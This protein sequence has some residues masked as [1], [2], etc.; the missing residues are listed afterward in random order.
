M[1]IS[2]HSS[3]NYTDIQMAQT[4]KGTVTSK[5]L[6]PIGASTAKSG[7]DII[8]RLPAKLAS[9][10]VQWGA[11]TVLSFKATPTVALTCGR[12]GARGFISRVHIGTQS[13][14]LGVTDL[15]A[16]FV[17]MERDTKIDQVI[18]GS[19]SSVYEGVT[20]GNIG[21]GIATTGADFSFTLDENILAN[22]RQAIYLGSQDE[23]EITL[24]LQDAVNMG[25][26]NAGA[27][28]EVTISNIELH[29]DFIKLEPDTMDMVRENND[30]FFVI[31]TEGVRLASSS[32]I[33]G[34][35]NTRVLDSN[36]RHVSRFAVAYKPVGVLTTAGSY[37][38]ARCYP[39]LTTAS[40]S[41]NS[42]EYPSKPLKGSPNNTAEFLTSTLEANGAINSGRGNSLNA[43]NNT[44]SPHFAVTPALSPYNFD[45]VAGVAT[46]VNGANQ[47]SFCLG[48]KLNALDEDSN[49]VYNGLSTIGA[50]VTMN[51]T[52]S[53]L[54]QNVV[55]N[56]WGVFTQFMVCDMRD[57]QTW[58]LVDSLDEVKQ[59][60]AQRGA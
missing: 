57:T 55:Q 38:S 46:N 52:S 26:W 60:Y 22:A 10:V 59:L 31:Q 17:G 41:I 44:D 12:S 47:G 35:Q 19:S 6:R 28:G 33:T 34:V 15:W 27:V 32:V 18:R 53:A 58:M 7:E 42:N 21:R 20:T 2:L 11:S 30:D 36:N 29:C 5:R 54:T 16:D 23:I 45:Q 37:P 3:L 40:V 25:Y 1:S 50:N 56:V 39:N 51:V 9:T 14:T 49:E 4:P 8:F 13:L 43:L 24:T 48:I